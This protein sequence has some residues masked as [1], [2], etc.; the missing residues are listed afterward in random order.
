ML[1]TNKGNEYVD[2]T[3]WTVSE[4]ANKKLTLASKCEADGMSENTV[5]K[6]LDKAEAA[7]CAAL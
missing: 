5:S 7:E 2:F 1:Q 4:E 3:G 6:I